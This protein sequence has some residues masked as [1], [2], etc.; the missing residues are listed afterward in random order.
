MAKRGKH[1]HPKQAKKAT[2]IDIEDAINKII[3]KENEQIDSL[4]T[5][6]L[7]VKTLKIRQAKIRLTS[8]RDRTIILIGF[9]G[10]CRVS[11]V[12]SMSFEQLEF[13]NDALFIKMDEENNKTRNNY[14][15]HILPVENPLHCPIA[16]LRQ[17][18]QEANISSGCLFYKIRNK[19]LDKSEIHISSQTVQRLVKEFLGAD[20]SSHSL[21]VG[22]AVAMLEAN[23]PTEII[24]NNGGW[25][26]KEI[27]WRY[28]DQYD[29]V[30]HNKSIL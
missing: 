16:T 15:K 19:G 25:E 18:I 29:V 12:A 5:K 11:E 21:R 8:L 14:R 17:Y 9:H 7:L 2:S 30:K 10:M 22:M 6:K 23:V 1:V 28:T 20:K 26:S 24:M 4:L 3:K 27:M 13:S